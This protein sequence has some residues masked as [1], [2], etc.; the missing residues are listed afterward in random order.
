MTSSN[1]QVLVLLVVIVAWWLWSITDHYEQSADRLFDRLS[2]AATKMRRSM[3]EQPQ[4]VEVPSRRQMS[5]W[6]PNRRQWW[7]I[8]SGYAAAAFVF[9]AAHDSYGD[10]P[11][12]TSLVAFIVIGAALL[13]WRLK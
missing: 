6:Y 11:E 7:A 8:W 9:F 1:I 4:K 3:S 2:L 13:V 12:P 10:D 5:G